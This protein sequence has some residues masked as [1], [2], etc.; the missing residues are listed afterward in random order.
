MPSCATGRVV[1]DPSR[2]LAI[3]SSGVKAV[4]VPDL[5]ESSTQEQAFGQH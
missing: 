3:L 5:D 1:M 4:V 2:I